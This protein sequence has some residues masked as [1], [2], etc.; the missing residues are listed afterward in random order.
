[1]AKIISSTNQLFERRVSRRKDSEEGLDKGK[2]YLVGGG[3]QNKDT[4]TELPNLV[5][6]TTVPDNLDKIMNKRFNCETC[7]KC[8]SHPAKK[9]PAAYI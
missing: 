2:P 3:K 4:S 8:I 1:M 7:Q 5:L 6:F 9:N